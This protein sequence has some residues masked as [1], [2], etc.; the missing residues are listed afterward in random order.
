MQNHGNPSNYGLENHGFRNLANIYWNYSPAL[1]VEK[2]VC[3]NEGELSA[4]G[5]LIASTGAHTGRSPKD[6][7]VVKYPE[8]ADVPIWW[9]TVNAPI[10]PEKF[11][12][13]LQKMLAYFQGK[14]VFVQDLRVGAHPRYTL[15]IRVITEK[16]WHSMFAQNLF[17]RLTP[18]EQAA[19][20]PE[21]TVIH[22]E[23]FLANPELDGTNSSTA[24]VVDFVK[25]IILICGTG[26][27]GEIKKSIFTIMNYILPLKGV[28]SMHCSANVGHR[29]DTALF[30]GLS[31]TGKTTLSS[32]P[33]R[34]LIGD[35]EHGW[36]DEGIF[37]FEGGCYAKTIRLS[38]EYEPIIWSA[39]RRF[40][41][42]LENVVYDPFTRAVNFDSDRITENTRGAYPIH[43]VPNHVPS[44]YAGHPEN[45]F[46]LTA[47]AFG[48][49]PPMAK[50]TREQAMFYFLSGYTSKL[51]GTET[52]LGAE[53]EATFS[54]CFGSP[55]LP[56]NPRIYADLLG[57]RIQRHNATVWLVNT[58]WT[59]G[60]YGVGSRFK[61]PYTRAMI[62]AV[63]NHALDDIPFHQ[64]DYFGLW[65]PE[66][67][68][69][70]PDEVLDPQTTW[71]DKAAYRLEARHLVARFEQNYKIF[72][73]QI[74][75]AIPASSTTPQ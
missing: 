44:G 52:G 2:A 50:L 36:C 42:V 43:F 48:V 66:H 21:F 68:P 26:Y 40:G 35:D 69:G 54:T 41:A 51:A 65:L 14:D 32:D 55:F 22:A 33:E 62:H 9:G 49:L 71:A 1:L 63:L 67:C 24:I 4:D 75:S 27:A 19:H 7:F 23:D 57:E 58:G 60:P 5:A 18:D 3:R 6:K 13:L 45:V 29:G 10:S 38:Q 16:A 64:E 61:L 25:R 72:S 17:L 47:D 59:G 11:D 31:G 8:L 12:L 53:P 28:L 15:P 56:L 46:F 34:Q 39:T 30:F 70:V 74:P 73:D 20:I 37:N